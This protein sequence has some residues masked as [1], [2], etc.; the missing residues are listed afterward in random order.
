[1]QMSVKTPPDMTF[2][3]LVKCAEMNERFPS[4]FVSDCVWQCLRLMDLPE[5]AN[6]LIETVKRYYFAVGR[7]NK[8]LPAQKVTQTT[9]DLLSELEERSRAERAKEAAK[10][11][12]E[13]HAR[14]KKEPLPKHL[15]LKISEGIDDLPKRIKEKAVWLRVK[16]NALVVSCVRDCLL[17]MDDPKKAVVPLPTVVDYWTISHTKPRQPSPNGIDMWVLRSL[18]GVVRR[19]SGPVLDTIVRLTVAEQWD[20]TLEQI[21]READVITDKREFKR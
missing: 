12:K 10:R 5:R 20:A 7:E 19:R 11:L 13:F 15:N 17:A 2:L 18:E 8:V 1:M 9:T 4:S 16:P 3:I 21:L 14:L 6:E